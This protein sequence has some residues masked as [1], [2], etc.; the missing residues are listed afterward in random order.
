MMIPLG[1]FQA[2]DM[3]SNSLCTSL[4]LLMLSNFLQYTYHIDNNNNKANRKGNKK[5]LSSKEQ[6]GHHK[7]GATI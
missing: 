5:Q 4:S 6:I 3:Y 2:T 7:H 1:N